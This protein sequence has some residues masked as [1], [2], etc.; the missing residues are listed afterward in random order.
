MITSFVR[1]GDE[2]EM[3]EKPSYIA[4]QQ[5][6][7]LQQQQ[8]QQQQ[9][10]QQSTHGVWQLSKELKLKNSKATRRSRRYEE[11]Y[12]DKDRAAAVNMG[13]RDI[14]QSL[15]LKRK[16]ER[17][18][19]LS[20]PEETEPGTLLALAGY[21]MTARRT[22]I[23]LSFINKALN[24][25]PEDKNA[26]VA[27]SKCY[28]LLGEAKHALEDAESA[29]ALDSTFIKGLYRKAEALYHLGNFEH[30]LMYFHRGLRMRPD[31]E[32]FRLGVQKAQQAI[33]NVIGLK[34]KTPQNKEVLKKRAER[35]LLG[36]LYA[37]KV[38][39]ED[40][41]TKKMGRFNLNKVKYI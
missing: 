19:A 28:L 21:E 27:R 38:Y 9:L 30:S 6:Q 7:S 17:S 16:Q 5:Q 37:D 18:K 24:L 13:S 35:H 26:L 20:L 10:H 23:A 12:T 22:N 8:F 34:N 4:Q 2:G 39:L 15:K 32:G 33:E 41:L 11:C 14:K 1:V 40:L 25:N 29:L 36:E 3:Q 31:M